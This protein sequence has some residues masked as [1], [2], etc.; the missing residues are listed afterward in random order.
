MDVKYIGGDVPWTLPFGDHFYS[1]SQ[2]SFT[3]TN[4]NSK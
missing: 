3:D 4:K 1:A 2:A